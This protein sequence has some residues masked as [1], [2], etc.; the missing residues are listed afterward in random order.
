MMFYRIRYAVIAACLATLLLSACG[1]GGKTADSE[2]AARKLRA[3]V[4]FNVALCVNNLCGVIDQ[5]ATLVVPFD[6]EYV[7]LAPYVMHGTMLVYRDNHWLLLDA[8]SKAALK[9]IGGDLHNAVPGYFGFTREGKVGLM[10]YQGNEVQ[11]P[12]FD[13]IF[14][15]G[16]NQYI[17]FESRGKHGLLDTQGKLLADALYDSISI[18]DDF[19][20]HAGLVTATRGDTHWIIDL[21]NGEQKEVPYDNLGELHDG[22]LVATQIMDHKSGLADTS[23]TLVVPMQYEWMGEPGEGLVAFRQK[24]D[25]DC[26]YLDYQGK[27]VIEPHFAG[28]ETFGRKGALVTQRDANGAYGKAGFID[29]S[30]AWLVPPTYEDMGKAGH[31]RLGMTEQVSGYNTVYREGLLSIHGVGI[32]DTNQGKELVAPIYEE[33]GVLTPDRLLFASKGGPRTVM[34]YMGQDRNTLPAVGLMDAGGKVLL[35]PER[36][37]DIKL[38]KSGRYLLARDGQPKSH[39]ALYDLDGHLLIPPRWHALQVD[40]KNAVI[41]AYEVEPQGED[42]VR[43]LMAAFDLAGKPL[44]EVRRMKCG[45]EQLFDGAG[46]VVWPQDPKPYCGEIVEG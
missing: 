5:N 32:F 40:E 6:N 18:R 43:H 11:P 8:R 35:P 10:D 14:S 22:H 15:G 20:R 28:C 37:V 42:E 17:G 25:G 3:P 30:G 12:R 38:H 39:E 13:A 23:G 45:A 44:F 16:E 4:P 26:G 27:V 46:K 19:D 9:T 36:Y 21:K 41:F 34:S 24:S 31:G 2:A 7:D 29:R 33:I 1:A